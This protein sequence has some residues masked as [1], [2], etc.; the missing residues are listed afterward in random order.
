MDKIKEF[1]RTEYDCA[2]FKKEFAYKFKIIVKDIPLFT[3]SI[4][5]LKMFFFIT[6]FITDLFN[7]FITNQPNLTLT[8]F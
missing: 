1:F 3:K 4:I 7:D 5:A 2:L 6:S 8:N